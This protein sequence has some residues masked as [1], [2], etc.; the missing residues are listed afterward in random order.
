MS[1]KCEVKDVATGILL[2]SDR[3]DAV[4]TNV[5]T[6]AGPGAP[7]V[8]DLNIIYLKLADNA[9]GLILA[10]LSPRVARIQSRSRLENSRKPAG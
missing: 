2:Y 5:E 9:V 4:Y 6:L 8:D 10:Q 1:V 3:F 7:S